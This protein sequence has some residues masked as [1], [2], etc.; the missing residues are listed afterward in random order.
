MRLSAVGFKEQR[1]VTRKSPS[2]TL[3]AA[4]YRKNA[5]A[6]CA[7][8]ERLHF[9]HAC[10]FHVGDPSSSPS[11]R[12]A[13]LSEIKPWNHIETSQRTPLPPP[14]PLPLLSTPISPLVRAALSRQREPPR[15]GQQEASRS[16]A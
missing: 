8:R 15:M 10:L 14:L 6:I 12:L 2:W 7:S 16:S 13:A 1:A 9:R 11:L 5:V 3:I 4:R